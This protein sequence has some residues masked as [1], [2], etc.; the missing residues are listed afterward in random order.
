MFKPLIGISFQGLREIPHTN[1]VMVNLKQVYKMLKPL[2]V[3]FSCD[4][5]K[6]SIKHR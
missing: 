5:T 4:G 2:D 1:I 6:F 3:F